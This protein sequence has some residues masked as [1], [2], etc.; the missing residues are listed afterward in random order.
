MIKRFKAINVDGEWY[1]GEGHKTYF[2]NTK[3]ETQADAERKAYLWMMQDAYAKAQ[4]IYNKGVEKGYFD[5]DC[6]GDYL[7]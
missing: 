5:E 7:A 3:C 2:P 6:F 4:E 1:V